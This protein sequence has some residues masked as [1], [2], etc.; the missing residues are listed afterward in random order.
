MK[1]RLGGFLFLVDA[2]GTDVS[3]FAGGDEGVAFDE[4]LDH[5]VLL[6]VVRVHL[7]VN[8]LLAFERNRA[9]N[10]AIVGGLFFKFHALFEFDDRR[11]EGGDRLHFPRL[12]VRLRHDEVRSELV[13]HFPEEEADANVAHEFVES[14]LGL[15]SPSAEKRRHDYG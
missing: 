2:F 3:G 6:L 11:F 15:Q 9:L 7:S 8:H 14:F 5:R 10:Q 12:L 1:E 13:A 4:A